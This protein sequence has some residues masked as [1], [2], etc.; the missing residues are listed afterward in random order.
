MRAGF[1]RGFVALAALAVSALAGCAQPPE[2]RAAEIVLPDGLTP[3]HDAAREN[4]LD[5]AKLLIDHGA[6]VNATDSSGC[7]PLDRALSKISIDQELEA[8]LRRHG[9]T[10]AEHC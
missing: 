8:V 3:L 1:R 5:M 4:S 7:T 10:C 6:D 2:R 9:G